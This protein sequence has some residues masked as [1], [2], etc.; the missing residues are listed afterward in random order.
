MRVAPL[1][2]LAL[3][4]CSGASMPVELHEIGA[5]EYEMPSDWRAEARTEAGRS[6]V[7][8]TP[9]ENDQKESITLIQS[10]PLPAMANAGAELVLGHLLEAQR[11]LGGVF[12]SPTI[13]TSKHGFKVAR[14]DGSFTPPERT[15]PYRRTHAVVIVDDRLVHIFYTAGGAT[16]NRDALSSVINSF[17]RKGA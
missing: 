8:W 16:P 11:G 1:L 13:T 3:L 5:F 12:G 6:V 4:A 10:E 9:S 7:E 2:P 14:V 15:Q 17:N